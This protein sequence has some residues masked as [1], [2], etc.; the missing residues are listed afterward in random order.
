M[1]IL[2]AMQ[3]LGLGMTQ[4]KYLIWATWLLSSA[5]QKF[6]EAYGV[7]P[8]TAADIWRDLHGTDIPE[9][10]VGDGDNPY[11]FLLAIRFLFT[12]DTEG[13]LSIFSSISSHQTIR[14]KCRVYARKMQLLFRANMGTLAENDHGFIFFMT[15][16]G[17]CCPIEEPRPF[18]T[19][20][21]CY[22]LG[23]KA[24]VNYEL[25]I[26]IVEQKVIW[27]FGP[28]QPGLHNDLAVYRLAL[29][30]EMQNMQDR[31]IIADGIYNDE[32]DVIS[33]K[34]ELDPREL[35]EF[36]DRALSRHEKFNGL[37]KNFN[38][39]TTKFRHGRENHFVAFEAVCC[40]CQYQL[41]NGSAA[42]F[43]AFP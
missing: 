5:E 7:T 31:R 3:F 42:L 22:K 8:Q 11:H 43:D 35:A 32:D 28:T 2:T 26:S 39:L 38:I 17:T 1:A 27:C 19:E 30:G 20:N 13:D 4:C 37:L 25:G 36:K 33:Q 15:I 40:L 41:D 21:S 6:R 34:S 16:D 23:G 29:R 18:S 9:A 10:V 12:Y 14:E 24:G